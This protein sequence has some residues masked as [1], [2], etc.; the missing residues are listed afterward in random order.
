[1]D[2]KDK[3]QITIAAIGVFGA[4][5]VALIANWKTLFPTEPPSAKSQPPLTQGAA[6]VKEAAS[7]AP[8]GNLG[9]GTTKP[10]KATTVAA[11]ASVQRSKSVRAPQE[12]KAPRY[13]RAERVITRQ[14]DFTQ[15]MY[16]AGITLGPNEGLIGVESKYKRYPWSLKID[17]AEVI[18][19]VTWH[20]RTET[21]V[22]EPKIEVREN[23]VSL[24]FAL[25]IFP[26]GPDINNRI[27][28][29][30]R[31]EYVALEKE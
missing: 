27:K 30:V 15:E 23:A 20:P 11:P 28:G 14:I 10:E 24:V 17:N 19:N 9:S 12:E 13:V 18:S 26:K 5:S 1:M 7:N 21:N 8:S 25:A 6:V 16:G 31:I 4:I 22:P 3:V 2:T 29:E